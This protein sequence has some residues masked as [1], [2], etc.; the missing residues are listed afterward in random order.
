MTRTRTLVILILTGAADARGQLLVGND[1]FT[2]GT[3]AWHIDLASE[4]ASPLW[5]AGMPEV[6][7][8]AASPQGSVY[9]S[10]GVGYWSGPFPAV[11]TR[12]GDF[13]VN[14]VTVSMVG[15]A[16]D[17]A[18]GTLYGSRNTSTADA[19]EGLYQIDPATGVAS[20]VLAV[21]PALDFDLGGLDYNPDDGYLY[22]AD[23]ASGGAGTGLFRIDLA[24]GSL[25]R[26]AAYPAGETDIDGLAIGGG[27]AYLIEDEPGDSIHVYDFGAGA[28]LADIANP[29]PSAQTFAGGAFIPEP[30]TL[31]LLCVAAGWIASRRPRPA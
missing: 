30:A 9:V 25:T 12:V 15:L 18:Q 29:M 23:D 28:Y 21:S 26:I 31:G 1:D 27:R 20:L 3:N 5:G 19:P 8:M 16:W 24:A 6:W 17:P 22:A 2:G 14:G 7:G 10:S 4:Q 11:P 13:T